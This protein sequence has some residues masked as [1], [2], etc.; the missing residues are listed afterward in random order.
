MGEG[1]REEVGEGE[2]AEGLEIEEGVGGGG[3][4]GTREGREWG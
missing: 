4:G 3:R 2:G 1:S